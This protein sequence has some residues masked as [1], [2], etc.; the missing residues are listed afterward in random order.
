M[1][2]NQSN[3]RFYVYT[4]YIRGKAAT[5]IINNLVNAWGDEAPSRSTIF[6]WIS[7]FKSGKRQSFKDAQRI[8]RPL[9]VTCSANV[10]KV[11]Q[12]LDQNRHLSTA[13]ICSELG[14][15]KESVRKI[16]HEELNMRKVCS[17][18][19]PHTLSEKNK[20]DRVNSAKHIRHQLA[21]LGDNAKQCFVSVDES[22][23]NFMPQLLKSENKC[24]L[25][26]NEPRP[27]IPK[28]TLTNKKTLLLLAFTA[29]KMFSIDVTDIGE[30]IDSQRY[31]S[32]AKK[33]INK[34]QKLRT[35]KDLHHGIHW[36]HD[37]AR[38]HS[39]GES[40]SFF[41]EC[42]IS[43]IWQAPYSPDFNQCDRWVFKFIKKHLR[44]ETFNNKDDVAAA[45]S[46]LMKDIPNDR[47]IYELEQLK[48]HCQA[49][50]DVAGEYV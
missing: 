39:S 20:I 32:F 45:V 19:I 18:W 4:E 50:I 29:A 3:F 9:T 8:G 42:G 15:G 16:I 30:T 37:N 7:D 2:P 44:K 47:F 31:I 36:M 35:N 25:A 34:W 27:K 48:C 1:E 6:R 17:T 5:K 33:T 43:L 10:A 41:E 49:V 46:R 14:I 21:L 13:F 23:I 24:W 12:M 26:A 38:P 28:Q 22:W 40:R 11:K